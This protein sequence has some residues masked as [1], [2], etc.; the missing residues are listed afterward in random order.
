VNRWQQTKGQ[1]YPLTNDELQV[2]R[3][4]KLWLHLEEMLQTRIT[5]E[6]ERLK[7]LVTPEGLAQHNSRVGKIQAFQ[8]ILNYPDYVKNLSRDTNDQ[9]RKIERSSIDR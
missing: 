5:E 3:G 8:E 2:L 4:Q 9:S 6:V 7:L 1:T